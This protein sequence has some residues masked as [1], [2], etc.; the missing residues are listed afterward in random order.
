[1]VRQNI[2]VAGRVLERMKESECD[3]MIENFCMWYGRNLEEVTEWM[4]ESCDVAGMQCEG[5]EF[6]QRRESEEEE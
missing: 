2:F 1:M 3:S 5:C 6:L 4:Q